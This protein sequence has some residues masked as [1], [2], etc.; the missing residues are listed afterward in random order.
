MAYTCLNARS[1]YICEFLSSLCVQEHLWGHWATSDSP[2]SGDVISEWWKLRR[3]RLRDTDG[4]CVEGA[5]VGSNSFCLLTG[6]ARISSRWPGNA[7][8]K[9]LRYGVNVGELTSV[10]RQHPLCFILHRAE[11]WSS[12]T[13]YQQH[14]WRCVEHT[15]GMFS[16]EHA[17]RVCSH[18]YVANL[19]LNQ[20]RD[21]I[22]HSTMG[23][24]FTIYIPQSNNQYWWSA[25]KWKKLRASQ[26]VII[27][28]I[29]VKLFQ[30]INLMLKDDEN[31]PPFSLCCHEINI[32]HILWERINRFRKCIIPF[33]TEIQISFKL[34]FYHLIIKVFS[35][36]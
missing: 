17:G 5:A 19:V 8:C 22:P 21:Q 35:L 15:A 25:I 29:K 12:L 32:L 16:P 9:S 11:Q 2:S 34:Q 18:C 3:P 10:V 20:K 26:I 14:C 31:K 1:L 24:V 6:S 7:A 13:F 23:D 4:E 33:K 28:I 27:N 30:E 36:V